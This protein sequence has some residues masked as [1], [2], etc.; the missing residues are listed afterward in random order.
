MI[1]HFWKSLDYN[2]LSLDASGPINSNCDVLMLP[3]VLVA[4]AKNQV[5]HVEVMAS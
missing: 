2:Y 5:S 3:V 4:A 1:F